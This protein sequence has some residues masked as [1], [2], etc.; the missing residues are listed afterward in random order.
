MTPFSLQIPSQTPM[1]FA[2][3]AVREGLLSEILQLPGFSGTV[4]CKLAIAD[5]VH[6]FEPAF[7]RTEN[8]APHSCNRLLGSMLLQKTGYF[9]CN[10][11]TVIRPSANLK[12]IYT[13]AATHFLFDGG[14]LCASRLKAGGAFRHRAESNA[15]VVF[16]GGAYV[17]LPPPSALQTKAEDLHSSKP[18]CEHLHPCTR[19][20]KRLVNGDRLTQ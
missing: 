10:R 8:F 2:M 19:V 1:F 12:R 7:R 16:F 9:L 3:Q 20:G 5:F 13:L 6:Q 14:S 4:S 17:L 18:L 11:Y 15:E